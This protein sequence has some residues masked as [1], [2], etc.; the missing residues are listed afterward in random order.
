MRKQCKQLKNMF[1]SSPNTW[2]PLP[3]ILLMGIAQYNARIFDLRKEGM[4]I[5]NMTKRENGTKH[6][7]YR[8]V[9]KVVITESQKEMFNPFV[10]A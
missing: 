2:I 1:L 4:Q 9:P 3:R 5:E 7:W 10:G 8:F 6:S